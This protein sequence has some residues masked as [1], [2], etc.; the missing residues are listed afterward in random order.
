MMKINILFFLLTVFLISCSSGEEDYEEYK[1]YK[2]REIVLNPYS[3]IDFK[4]VVRIGS[5]SHEHILSQ[6]GLENCWNR[7]IRNI[8]I[9]NYDPSVPLN[10]LDI[11]ETTTYLDWESTDCNKKVSKTI[12]TLSFNDF[13]DKDGQYVKVSEIVTL[14]NAERVNLLDYPYMLHSLYIGSTFGDAGWKGLTDDA[15]AWRVKHPILNSNELWRNIIENTTEKGVFGILAHPLSGST[16]WTDATAFVDASKG[17]IQG[18]E[19]FNQGAT[20]GKNREYSIF[21]DDLLCG[22][23]HLWCLSA[24]DWQG[25]RGD[26]D[27]NVDRGGQQLLLPAD[28][29][30]M[31]IGEKQHACLRAYK[32]GTF[33]PIGIG[34]LQVDSIVVNDSL[35]NIYMNK[36]CVLDRIVGGR[37]KTIGTV[38]E[39]SIGVNWVNKYIRFEAFLNDGDFVYTQPIFVRD[40]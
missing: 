40:K 15:I 10:S 19:T 1:E 20:E 27:V 35:I 33:F 17:I 29:D 21:Y 16:S 14:P 8:N 38:K 25:D 3:D 28:Y 9:S 37:R 4:N 26:K 2:E 5:C 30:E 11:T 6:K 34:N 39:Y 13:V 32:N 31:S 22:G 7:G 36:P 23:R 18:V 12:Q 24:T